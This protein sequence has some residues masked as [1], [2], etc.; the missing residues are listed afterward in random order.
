MMELYNRL[1]IK[2]I[3]D[4]KGMFCPECGST[5]VIKEG[6]VNKQCGNQPLVL[7]L[8]THTKADVRR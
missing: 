2:K 4:L 8:L 6:I 1:M 5:A 7:F 3:G